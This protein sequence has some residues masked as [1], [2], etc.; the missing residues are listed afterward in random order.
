MTNKNK[1]PKPV[2]LVVLDGWGVAQDYAGNAITQ[3]NTPVMDSLIEEYPAT[4]LQ[5]SGEAVGLPWGEAGNSEVGHLSLGLGRVFYQDLPRINRSINDGSF[6]EHKILLK[7]VEKIKKYDSALHIMGL[8]S[9]GGVHASIEHL[10]FLLQFAQ[11]NNLK[12]VYLH[13]ILDGRDTAMDAGARFVQDVQNKIKDYGVGKI[14]TISGRFYAMDRN[15]NWDRTEKAYLALTEGQ[16]NQGSDPLELVLSSYKK[17]IYD[18]EFVPAVITNNNKVS[19]VQDNDVFVFFNY[20]PDRA[21][22]ITKAFVLKDFDKFNRKKYL[23]N[24]TF[25]TFTEYEKDL[26]VEVLFPPEKIKNTLGEI[27]SQNNLRQLRIAET[28]KYAHV[29]Y[30]FNGGIEKELKGEDHILIPSPMVDNYAD[31]PEMSAL[32]ITKTLLEKIDENIY[33]FILVNFAN[34]DMIGHTGNIKAA[35]IGVETVDECLGRIVK[36]VLKYDGLVLITADHGNAEIMFNMQSGQI[37]KEH[38]SNP[39]PFILVGNDY[40]GKNFEWQKTPV[41]DLSLINPQGILPDVAP[42]IL[43][44]LNIKKPKEMTGFSII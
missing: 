5:A 34:A 21:R 12:K 26:P 29:T 40:R 1:I 9:D 8:S 42:T 11:R 18:E 14:A 38:T 25:I 3:A 28:E 33:D 32:E 6:F 39:V 43:K 20:R 10:Y 16:G 22:Q 44:I 7:A 36:K 37:D 15:N 13:L 27:L 2:V 31:T 4:T 35:V 41:S 23:K 24:L 30:F 19:V 17:K